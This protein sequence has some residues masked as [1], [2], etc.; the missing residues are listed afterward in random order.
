MALQGFAQL[1]LGEYEGAIEAFSASLAIEPRNS[2][3]LQSRGMAYFKLNQFSKAQADYQAAKEVDAEDP[4]N[5]IGLGMSLAMQ[6]QVYPALEVLENFLKKNP[7]H[8][9]TNLQLGLLQIKLGAI[10][11]GREYLKKA[12]DCR[13]TMAERRMIESTLSEQTKLDN[14]RYYRPDFEALRKKNAEERAKA[15]PGVFSRLRTWWKSFHV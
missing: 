1:G 6:N 7:F 2:K 14:R 3:V 15:G 11:K 4:E 5:W 8:A 12:L 13:P 10:N 9:R